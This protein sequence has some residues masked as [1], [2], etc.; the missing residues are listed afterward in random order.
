MASLEETW[1]TVPAITGITVSVVDLP[2]TDS[3]INVTHSFSEMHPVTASVP[4]RRLLCSPWKSSQKKTASTSLQ[5]WCGINQVRLSVRT[6]T[7]PCWVKAEPALVI[8]T[9]EVTALPGK[10]GSGQCNCQHFI[11]KLWELFV[12][13]SELLCRNT[14]LHAGMPLV[15][16]SSTICSK[17]QMKRIIFRLTGCEE[18]EGPEQD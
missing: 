14:S 10:R 12:N 8:Y 6:H 13:C 15:P 1:I 5:G 7:S 17:T 9:G 16:V 4:D 3:S 11:N 2:L 18:K